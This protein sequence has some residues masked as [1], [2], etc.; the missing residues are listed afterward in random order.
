MSTDEN[1]EEAV[2][3]FGEM[4]VESLRI[5]RTIFGYGLDF[6]CFAY[7]FPVLSGF[8]AAARKRPVH[9]TR[10]SLLRWKPFVGSGCARVAALC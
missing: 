5:W 4:Q 3:L 6:H 7:L 2:T 1:D 10:P 8:N 9:G